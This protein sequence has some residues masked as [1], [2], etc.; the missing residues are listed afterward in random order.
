MSNAAPGPAP[1]PPQPAVTFDV[2][3][4][5]VDSVLASPGQASGFEIHNVAELQAAVAQLEQ[6]ILHR[7]PTDP[8]LTDSLTSAAQVSLQ[9][10]IPPTHSRTLFGPW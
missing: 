5:T 3:S 1:V 9:F 8:S 6:Y 7:S 4:T 10:P 2:A